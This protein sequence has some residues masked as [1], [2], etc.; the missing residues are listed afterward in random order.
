MTS[1]C[2]IR[3]RTERR[4]QVKKGNIYGN[5]RCISTTNVSVT[6]NQ[7]CQATHAYLWSCAEDLGRFIIR[8]NQSVSA[9]VYLTFCAEIAELR[10]RPLPACSIL[11]VSRFHG[12]MVNRCTYCPERASCYLCVLHQSP[13]SCAACHRE[14]AFIDSEGE[15]GGLGFIVD[16]LH[17][18][19]DGSVARSRPR[20]KFSS[21]FHAYLF[22]FS[23]L[24]SRLSIHAVKPFTKQETPSC[25][26]PSMSSKHNSNDDNSNLLWQV[27]SHRLT[28]CMSRK[29]H[30]R[31][32][33][34]RRIKRRSYDH[35]DSSHL[36]QA[37]PKLTQTTIMYYLW[38]EILVPVIEHVPSSPTSFHARIGT[39]W[40]ITSRVH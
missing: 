35:A 19:R 11:C 39:S 28:T 34:H 27:A 31:F 12:E 37:V 36:K 25:V 7:Q 3:R 23:S 5:S 29:P 10:T 40:F 18:H 20:R 26:S 38:P 30:P 21:N 1:R 9:A 13:E 2:Q 33:I 16:S 15:K 4:M 8:S 22:L 17:L 6:F 14:L 24:R 32:P